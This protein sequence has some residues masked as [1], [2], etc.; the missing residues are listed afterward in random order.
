MYLICLVLSSKAIVK[1]KGPVLNMFLKSNVIDIDRM[2]FN[3]VERYRMKCIL[4][5][6]P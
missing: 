6:H 3:V 1:I 4:S 2:Y 5:G